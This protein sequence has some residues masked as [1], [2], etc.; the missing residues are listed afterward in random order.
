MMLEINE[1]QF[2]HV[3][4]YTVVPKLINIAYDMTSCWEGNNAMQ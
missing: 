4:Q 3:Y 1:C 2:N